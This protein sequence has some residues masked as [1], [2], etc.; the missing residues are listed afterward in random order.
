MA[1]HL[2]LLCDILIKSR[3][4]K[5]YTLDPIQ[6]SSY[7]ARSLTE[8]RIQLIHIIAS[9][10]EVNPDL[11]NTLPDP[12]WSVLVSWYFENWFV[13]PP[14]PPLLTIIAIIIIIIIIINII[15]ITIITIIIILKHHHHYL[16][17]LLLFIIYRVY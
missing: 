4:P 13:P 9:T 1:K 3:N 14:P 2:N 6:F 12:I 10:I 16:T 11:L 8:F 17:S 7:T 15:I 5:L